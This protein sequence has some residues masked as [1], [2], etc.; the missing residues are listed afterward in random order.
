MTHV[1]KNRLRVARRW[2]L[3]TCGAAAGMSIVGMSSAGMSAISQAPASSPTWF[4]PQAGLETGGPMQVAV[5][6][7]PPTGA[8]I[9]F[10]SE[11]F[12]NLNGWTDLSQAVT[13]GNSTVAR[14]AFTTGSY[15]QLTRT[16]SNNTVG[17]T[18]YSTPSSLRTFTAL[19][20]R[21]ATPINHATNIVTI[22]FRAAW[23][24]LD[25]SGAG[26]N[27]RFMVVLTHSYPTSGLDTTL[28]KRL[29]D[30][31][32]TWWARP[33][34]HLRIRS[35]NNTSATALL[36][37]GGGRSN[38]GEFETYDANRDGR[39]DWWLPGFIS[40][41]NGVS[42]GTAADFPSNSWVRTPQGI[43]STSFRNYRYVVKPD[44]QEVWYDANDNGT[45]EST[46]LKARMPL[47]QSST[48]PLYYYFPR[49]EGIRLY[50][51][52]AGGPDALGSDP[53]QVLVDRL[54]VSVRPL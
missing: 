20:H 53:G 47:P 11:D 35:G 43:A 39:P 9:V 28:N 13:W 12:Y 2:L 37:Y 44:A 41:A 24:K 54:V 8:Q 4:R 31:S 26:E 14:S 18:G 21:F 50:W 22:D 23:T 48:A 6:P 7:P 46:E 29:N 33:A 49:F 34:Y 1:P 36:Q 51:R 25:T 10:N 19:D 17:L 40:G 45:F 30:F 52:G 38:L 15:V 27:G 3:L 16:G 5:N 32:T 42:P